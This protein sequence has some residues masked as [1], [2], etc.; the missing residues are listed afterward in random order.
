ML[1]CCLYGLCA[2]Q[3]MISNANIAR[4]SE[5][6]TSHNV[7]C[8]I[9]LSLSLTFNHLLKSTNLI[10]H[11]VM[12]LNISLLRRQSLCQFKPSSQIII[13][14]AFNKCWSPNLVELGLCNED[15]DDIDDFHIPRLGICKLLLPFLKNEEGASVIDL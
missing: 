6:D 13:N 5:K 10:A 15:I 1:R 9:S 4:R 2:F 3:N 7:D 11:L 8:L 14:C 12:S